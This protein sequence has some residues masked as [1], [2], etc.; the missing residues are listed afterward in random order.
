MLSVVAL[1]AGLQAVLSVG[2]PPSDLAML[3]KWFQRE[4][5]VTFK[6]LFLSDP[7]FR[8]PAMAHLRWHTSN[9]LS[10]VHRYRSKSSLTACREEI[11]PLAARRPQL[12]CP[13]GALL[14]L[15]LKH[16]SETLASSD[17]RHT[18][19]RRLQPAAAD[20]RLQREDPALVGRDNYR[21]MI[22]I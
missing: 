22:I 4:V 5:N 16:T 19:T 2:P 8:I 7:P 14:H 17:P 9:R 1:S 21:F 3:Q 13:Y 15:R 10:D 12:L 18:Q 20:P 11:P 6:C